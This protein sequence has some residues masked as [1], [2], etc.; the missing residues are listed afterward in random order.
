MNWRQQLIGVPVRIM[1]H[2]AEVHIGRI[3]SIKEI[4]GTVAVIDFST[5]DTPDP[6][7]HNGYIELVHVDLRGLLLLPKRQP[8]PAPKR[9]L[10][11]VMLG[12]NTAP[13]VS[14]LPPSVNEAS[15]T[16]GADA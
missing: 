8:K 3:G 12:G 1:S 5:P 7:G 15:F 10:L 4:R 16:V 9:R 11:S 14:A 6:Y 2:A 13:A